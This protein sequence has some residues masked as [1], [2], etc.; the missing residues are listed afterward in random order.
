MLGEGAK[1]SLSRLSY[2]AEKCWIHSSTRISPA[3]TLGL[4][5]HYI[6]LVLVGWVKHPEDSILLIDKV[7]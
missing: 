5:L 2:A 4:S 7:L 3:V 1:P 6:P